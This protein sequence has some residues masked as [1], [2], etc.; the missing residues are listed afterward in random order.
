M[1]L[2]HALLRRTGP[3][4]EYPVRPVDGATR[5]HRVRF[6][7]LSVIT[8]V[9]ALALL[10]T[11]SQVYWPLSALAQLTPEL[12]DAK[13]AHLSGKLKL[14]IDLYTE[15]LKKNPTSPEA[16]NWRGMAYDD[17]GD[18]EKALADFN[19]AIQISPNYADAY[20]NRGEVFRKKNMPQQ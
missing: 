13:D 11:V 4:D 3:K 17:L 12:E 6:G 7:I 15:A 1:K 14:S 16:Y 10:L 18:L 8:G 20:N 19:R 5:R 2:L 9:Y